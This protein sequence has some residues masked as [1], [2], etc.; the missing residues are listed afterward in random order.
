MSNALAKFCPSSCDVPICR[1]LVSPIMASTVIV[2]VAPANRSPLVL[3]PG[4]TGT[5]SMLT[6]KSS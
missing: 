5:A 1:A 3:R 2:L 6:M 4:S